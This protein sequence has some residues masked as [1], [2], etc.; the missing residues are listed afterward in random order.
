MKKRFLCAALAALLI[1]FSLSGCAVIN[2]AAAPGEVEEFQTGKIDGSKYSNEFFGIGC[3]L[4][5]TWTILNEEEIAERSGLVFDTMEEGGM[6][7]SAREAMEN[8]SVVFDFFAQ[9]TDNTA[10]INITVGNIGVLYGTALT[11]E[12]YID[13]TTDQ[14]VQS[15]ESMGYENITTNKTTV[16]LAGTEHA[17]LSLSGEYSGVPIYQTLVVLRK[18]VYVGCVAFSCGGEDFSSDLEALFYA[19]D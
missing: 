13:A 17:A 18:G 1:S 6:D 15:V 9:K 14:M 12:G 5:D 8:G 3:E 2:A 10:A 4:D 7:N 16:T 11:E 19:L